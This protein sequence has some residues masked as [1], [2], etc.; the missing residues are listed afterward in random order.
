MLDFLK[1]EGVSCEEG[2]Q[3]SCVEE[4]GLRW[5]EEREKGRE[6]QKQTGICKVPSV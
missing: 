4:G 2:G 6:G 1:D 3:E 5:E